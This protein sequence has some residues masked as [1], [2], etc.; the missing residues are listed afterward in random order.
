M[1]QRVGI[2]SNRCQSLCSISGNRRR[3]FERELATAATLRWRQHDSESLGKE[4]FELQQIRL[5]TN[6]VTGYGSKIPGH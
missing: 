3:S 6:E 4:I 2:S 5:W 1:D